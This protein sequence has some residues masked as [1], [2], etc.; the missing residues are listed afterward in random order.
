MNLNP[1]LILKAQEIAIAN[2][3]NLTKM[4]NQALQEFITRYEVQND[5]TIFRP[6]G[7]IKR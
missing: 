3:L 5:S 7:A 4:M 2:N 6:I 1:E